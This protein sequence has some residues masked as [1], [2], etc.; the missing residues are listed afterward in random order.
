MSAQRSGFLQEASLIAY[1]K[2]TL[3]INTLFKAAR[4][5]ISPLAGGESREK[6]DGRVKKV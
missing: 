5:A 4:K 1:P 6:F 2:A 3:G